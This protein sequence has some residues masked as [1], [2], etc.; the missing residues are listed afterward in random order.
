METPWLRDSAPR[1][2]FKAMPA[3]IQTDDAIAG[4]RDAVREF[5]DGWNLYR[6]I[7]DHDYLHHRSVSGS[8]ARW[9]DGREPGYSWLD[10]G[11]GDAAFSAELLAGRPLR[12]YTGVDLSSVALGLARKN[13]ESLEV[14]VT[15]L[16]GDFTE[17]LDRV[18]G[19]VDLVYIGLS[20]HHL[21]RREK[22]RFFEAIHGR[23]SRGGALIVYD[24]VLNPGETRN[25]YLGRWV[26]NARWSWNALTEG[27][28]DGAVGHVTS[29]DHPEEITTLNR[30]AISAGFQ[31]AEILF[32][33]RTN[34]YALMVFRVP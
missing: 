20:L 10:L 4:G 19:A 29:S 28:L 9:L 6:R 27:E 11:C 12:S 16:E 8:L 13:L 17:R 31:P 30:F 18:S 2:L 22:E 21:L 26:D 15:L 14:P 25:L 24:P 1:L 33:D 7:V 5:F 23:I 3:E 34:F 32:M